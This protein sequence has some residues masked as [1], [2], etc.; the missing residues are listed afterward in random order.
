MKG[1]AYPSFYRQPSLWATSY[2]LKIILIPSS[3]IF[4]KSQPPI[5]KGVYTMNI[6]YDPETVLMVRRIRGTFELDHYINKQKAKC[7]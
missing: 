5:N 7:K 3:M 2:F 1:S 6:T 4:Q